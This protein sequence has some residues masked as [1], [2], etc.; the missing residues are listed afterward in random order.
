MGKDMKSIK[1]RL[2]YVENELGEESTLCPRCAR[3][4]QMSQEQLI[5]EAIKC[6]IPLPEEVK[7]RLDCS[8]GSKIEN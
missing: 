8:V 7:R 6:G 3:L 4:A 2:D 5:A 1:S